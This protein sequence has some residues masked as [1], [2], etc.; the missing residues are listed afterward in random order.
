MLLLWRKLKCGLGFHPYQYWTVWLIQRSPQDELREYAVE[1]CRHC[2]R[3]RFFEV[4]GTRWY[5]DVA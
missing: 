1:S 2:G 4:H 5:S 3:L